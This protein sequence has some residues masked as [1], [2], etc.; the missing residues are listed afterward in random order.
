M[1]APAFI[2]LSHHN[3]IPVSLEPA[4]EAGVFGVIHKATEGLGYVDA[5][6]EARR[7][8]VEQAGMLWGVYH[9][10][11]PGSMAEQVQHFV[12]TTAPYCDVN[13]L[14]ALDWED[15]DVS[16]DDAI[17]FMRLLTE[18]TGHHPV[19]YSG[20]VVKEALDG[21]ECADLNQYRLW[22][23]QYGPEAELPP[24]W[25][26]YWAWQYTENGAV[27][28]V[29]P[30]TDLNAFDGT[31]AELRASWSGFVDSIEPPNPEVIVI[32]PPGVDVKVITRK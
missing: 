31:E 22:L 17:E 24:G 20:H 8:L 2:D 32:V 4:R 23:C 21:V 5:T 6:L 27:P 10:V 1:L 29:T 26:S 12:D 28:G 30:P 15:A 25:D 13:T 9:F 19:L 14:Y 16:I 7:W 11:R 18:R 3:S